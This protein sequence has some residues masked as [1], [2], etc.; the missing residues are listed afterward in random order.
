MVSEVEKGLADA[1]TLIV[2]DE[3]M[4]KKKTYC[5]EYIQVGDRSD[6]IVRAIVKKE[7]EKV[8]EKHGAVSYNLDE[9]LS[10]YISGEMRNDQKG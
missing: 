6:E 9:V 4:P 2:G 8:L 5:I 7:I 3:K 10:K 1:H